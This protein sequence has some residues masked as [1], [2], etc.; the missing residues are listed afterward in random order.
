MSANHTKSYRRFG[1]TIL[2]TALPLGM[3][4]WCASPH[5]AQALGMPLAWANRIPDADESVI[6]S[7]D[8]ARLFRSRHLS[9]LN[10]A[11]NSAI[12]ES[13]LLPMS[14]PLSFAITYTFHDVTQWAYDHSPAA[15]LIESEAAAIVRGIDTSDDNGCCAARLIQDVLQEVAL[16]RRSDSANEAAIVFH[17]LVA[18]T[19]AVIYA[20]EAIAV[21]DKLIALAAEAER[22][23]IQDANPL[24]LRQTRL[25]LVDA[26]TEQS[27][28]GLKLRQ[29][30]SR[31][32]GRSEAEVASAEMGESLPT[33]APSIVA[34][35]AV[36]T[37]LSQRHDLRAVQILCRD[38]RRC[39]LDAARLLMGTIS[40]GV[41]LSLA[42][43]ATGILK[44]LKEDNTDNDFNARRCQCQSLQNSLKDVIRNETL[45]AVLD[46]R[47]AGARLK[48][49]DEQLLLASA[50]LDDT[51]GKVQLDVV[52]PGSDY[53]VELEIHQLRGDQL[54]LQKDLAVAIDN[55]N[56]AQG[57]ITQ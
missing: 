46:V 18:A 51:R 4:G 28:N 23:D 54:A 34:A 8:D 12:I 14:G 13:T 48:L 40:P 42:T 7:D 22:L 16:A 39:N 6:S 56:H 57:N 50:R 15:A 36:A 53:I 44:C 30:L 1:L 11:E 43:A 31:L 29:E 10:A 52:T 32:T 37:A 3:V 24:K 45:Q 55:L 9:D 20:E 33:E 35:D 26:K 17:Q 41:G 25:D 21:Q 38:L 2:A 49:V 5:A 27:F 47:S 19:Q